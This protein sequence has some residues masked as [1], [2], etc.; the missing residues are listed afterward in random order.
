MQEQLEEVFGKFD[1]NRSDLIPVLQSIQ[2]RLGYLP[3]EAMS[4]TARFLNIAESSVYGV[5]TFY[6]QFYL[7]PQGRHKVKVCQ[8]TACHVRGS[9]AITKAVSN[10][11]GIKPGETSKDFE[12]TVERVACFGACAIAPVVVIDEKVYGNMTPEKTTKVLKAIV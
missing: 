7:T 11:L 2:D 8:G 1:G 12:F 4:K 9:E 10:L 3:E 6:S 5:A